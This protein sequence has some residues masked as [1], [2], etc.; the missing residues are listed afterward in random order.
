MI[1]DEPLID[2]S[3]RTTDQGCGINVE[4][5]YPKEKQ[6]LKQQEQP[7]FELTRLQ[8]GSTGEEIVS[9]KWAYFTTTNIAIGVAVIFAI[10]YINNQ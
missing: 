3:N 5:M 7:D 6:D 8:K 9:E 4:Q 1:Q 10:F 2:I